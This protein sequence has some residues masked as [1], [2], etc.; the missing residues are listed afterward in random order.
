M[1]CI[2]HGGHKESEMIER[3]SLSLLYVCMFEGL[4][5]WDRSLGRVYP[6]ALMNPL[7][8]SQSPSPLNKLILK[9]YFSSDHY[10]IWI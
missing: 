7:I 1:D 8:M 6:E 5:P 2:V 4:E 9:P 3:L 10:V